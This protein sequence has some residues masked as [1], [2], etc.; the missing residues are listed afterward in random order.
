[1][2]KSNHDSMRRIKDL[3]VKKVLKKMKMNKTVKPDS[4]NY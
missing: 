1:M 4:K 2:E 3:E